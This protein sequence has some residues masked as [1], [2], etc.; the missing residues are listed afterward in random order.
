MRGGGGEQVAPVEGRGDR[1][2]AVGRAGEVDGLHRAAGPRQRGPEQPVVGSDE[3]PLVGRAHGHGAPL[4]ADLGVDDGEM[5]AGRQVGQGI[6][7]QHGAGPDV[8]A[9][10]AV[11]DVDHARLGRDPGDHRVADPDELVRGS[12]SPTG[13]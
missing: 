8:V 10:D 5:D 7:Q 11:P 12:R 13:R 3:Q 2:Q 1:L 4:P 9:G 6:A